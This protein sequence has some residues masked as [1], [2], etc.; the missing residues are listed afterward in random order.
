MSR[1]KKRGTKNK[2]DK[3]K[4]EE[5]SFRRNDFTPLQKIINIEKVT[6]I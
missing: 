2:E 6:R 1:E 3:K 4:L 5:S